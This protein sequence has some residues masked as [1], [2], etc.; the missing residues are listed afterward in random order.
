MANTMR[1]TTAVVKVLAA[2]LQ[3]PAAERYGL[4]LMAETGLP[5][6]TLYPILARLQRAGWVDAQWEQ[7][8][9]VTA[10]RPARRYYVLTLDGVASARAELAVLYQQLSGARRPAGRPQTA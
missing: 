8:D 3:D 6:G 1:V 10:G 5:S 2:L 4:D 7:I 9:P